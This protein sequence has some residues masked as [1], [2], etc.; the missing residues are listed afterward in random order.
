MTSG[1]MKV[2]FSKEEKDKKAMGQCRMQ[3]VKSSR[4]RVSPWSSPTCS[5]GLPFQ[6]TVEPGVGDGH[7]EGKQSEFSKAR[8]TMARDT[9]G[10]PKEQRQAERGGLYSLP[11]AGA[12]RHGPRQQRA[13]R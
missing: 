12:R 3:L 13:E 4:A 10:S 8:A 2:R 7:H 9:H 11:P 6:V 1:L 5:P